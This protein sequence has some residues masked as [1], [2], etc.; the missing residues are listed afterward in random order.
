MILCVGRL[1]KDQRHKGQD[2]LIRAMSLVRQ[3][4][5]GA[6]LVLV[7]SGDWIDELKAL[8]LAQGVGDCVFLP[9]FVSDKAR[10]ALYSHCAVFAM[11]SKGEGFGLVYLEAMRWSKPCV[12]GAVDAARDVIVDGKTGLLLA[13]PH[14]HRLLAETLC[15][16]LMDPEAAQAMGMAGRKRL[17]ERYLFTHFKER[18]LRAVDWIQ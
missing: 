6:Q 16:L 5:P 2:V 13:E 10:D 14:D 1:W 4:F 17:E 11:P 8:A 9:G 18:F 15:R 7:G 12:G 3:R